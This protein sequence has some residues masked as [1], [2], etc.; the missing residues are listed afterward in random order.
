VQQL[1]SGPQQ[2]K[3]K[4]NNLPVPKKMKTAINTGATCLN[5][6]TKTTINPC[7][8]VVRQSTDGEK[9]ENQISTF[10]LGGKNSTINHL[11]KKQEQQ[12]TWVAQ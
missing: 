5:N 8:K 4:N 1:P 10:V 3:N 2:N 9:T 6:Q 12:L 7:N 11:L